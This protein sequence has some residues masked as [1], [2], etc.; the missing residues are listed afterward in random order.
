[1]HKSFADA[2]FVAPTVHGVYLGP[3]NW[4][5][6]LAPAMLPRTLKAWE[7]V[8]SAIADRKIIREFSNMFLVHAARRR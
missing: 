3:V 5:E 4:V 6:R 2:G 7:A 1:L 8:D